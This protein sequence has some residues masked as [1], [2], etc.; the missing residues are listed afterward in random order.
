M[1][2]TIS[3]LRENKLQGKQSNISLTIEVIGYGSQAF[4]FIYQGLTFFSYN[5]FYWSYEFVVAEIF[6]VFIARYISI[7]VPLLLAK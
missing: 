4:V 3:R 6:I 5:D 2:G 1:H 7:I